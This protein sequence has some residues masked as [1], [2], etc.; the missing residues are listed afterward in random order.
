MLISSDTVAEVY[1]TRLILTEDPDHAA[2]D[3]YDMCV[4]SFNSPKSTY[5]EKEATKRFAENVMKYIS[6]HDIIYAEKIMER[7]MDL[8]LVDMSK[9]IDKP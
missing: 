2:Q 1:A 4:V 7:Y 3:L 5:E 9:S 8:L 6:E